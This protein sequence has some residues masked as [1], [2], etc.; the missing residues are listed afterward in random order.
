MFKNSQPPDRRHKRASAAPRWQRERNCGYI[1]QP[2]CLICHPSYRLTAADTV[3]TSRDQPFSFPLRRI[4]IVWLASDI[5]RTVVVQPMTGAVERGR[6]ISA[7][8]R[9]EQD[10]GADRGNILQPLCEGN[11]CRCAR[12]IWKVLHSQLE[13][14]CCSLYTTQPGQ[15]LDK[16][17][18]Y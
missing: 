13:M 18:F 1:L 12:L 8:G 5:I 4:W 15:T 9:G 10:D 7:V 17:V 14:C 2:V 6:H 16:H 3:C 11:L